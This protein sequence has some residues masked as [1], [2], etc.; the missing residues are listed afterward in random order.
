MLQK[1][2]VP[3]SIIMIHALGM[4]MV[5]SFMISPISHHRQHHHHSVLFA[6]RK[7]DLMKNLDSASTTS[8]SSKK[9]SERKRSSTSISRKS[10]KIKNKKAQQSSP[11]SV[12]ASSSSSSNKSISPAISQ[13]AASVSSSSDSSSSTTKKDKIFLSNDDDD[14]DDAS[15]YEYSAFEQKESSSN[16]NSKGSS[17]SRRER[18]SARKASE[19]ILMKQTQNILDELEEEFTVEK[20]RDLEKILSLTQKLI[21]LNSN[22][23]KNDIQSLIKAKEFYGYKL[24]WAGSDEAICHI[25]TGLHKVPLA[26]LQEVFLNIGNKAK[27]EMYEVIRILG[28]FPNVK[29]TLLGDVSIMSKN[30]KRNNN[31]NNNEK[32]LDIQFNSMIDGT[33][34][35]ILAGTSENIRNVDLSV[36]YASEQIVICKVPDSDDE[37]EEEKDDGSNLLIFFQE[38]DVEAELELLRV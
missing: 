12:A 30:K 32:M 21:S 35:E 11:S 23:Q 31:N 14:D 7:G 19:A 17:S 3:L 36:L 1:I 22:L 27:I 6:R 4:S 26:R 20:N 16:N 13:W 5:N 10:N 2:I 38:V 24:V 8:T 37:E 34:K 18:Q 9:K 15:I 33:G 29:N 25:G 28:P